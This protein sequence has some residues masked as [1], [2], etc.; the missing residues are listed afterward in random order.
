VIRIDWTEQAKGGIRKLDDP[1]AMRVL[2]T[3][4]RFAEFG[5][6]DLKALQGLSSS[7]EF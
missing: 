2:H 3:L 4:H 7:F 6:R 5:V 1:T